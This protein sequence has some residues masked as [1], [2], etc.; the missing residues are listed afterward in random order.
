MYS[1]DDCEKNE[2]LTP[3]HRDYFKNNHDGDIKLNFRVNYEFNFR[4]QALIHFPY[5][6][7]Q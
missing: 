2:M 5:H 4:K 7:G 6:A 1:R 3:R